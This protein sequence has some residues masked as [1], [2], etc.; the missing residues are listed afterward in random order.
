VLKNNSSTRQNIT[1]SLNYKVISIVLAMLLVLATAFTARPWVRDAENRVI[2]VTGEATVTAEADEFIFYPNWSY[3]ATNEQ[4]GLSQVSAKSKE[5]VTKLKE[6]GIPEQNIKVTSSGTDS[7]GM[8][9][10]ER[11]LGTNPTYYLTIQVTTTSKEQAQTV[12]DYLIDTGPTGSI[13]PQGGFSDT[14]QKE[15]ESQARDEATKDA[16]A[17]AD[18]TASNLGFKVGKVKTVSDLTP[19]YGIY[20]MMDTAV[21]NSNGA[22]SDKIAVQPGTNDLNYT[23]T[24]EYYIE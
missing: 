12:Q 23:I 16:R 22:V 4:E 14:K 8:Y 3:T 24:V 1:F 5:V 19:G 6:L 13:T 7:N 11:E 9:Y 15:L 18:Q 21:T 2:S 20:P 17:K 10:P